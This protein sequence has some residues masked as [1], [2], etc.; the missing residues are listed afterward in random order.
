MACCLY[1]MVMHMILP[2]NAKGMGREL[3]AMQ[4]LML[5]GTVCV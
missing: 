5:N 3:L 4:M 1:K 2:G